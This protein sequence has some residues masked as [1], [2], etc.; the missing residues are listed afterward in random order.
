L[1]INDSLITNEPKIVGYESERYTENLFEIGRQVFSFKVQIALGNI[2]MELFDELHVSFVS[3]K[4][5]WIKASFWNQRPT[6]YWPR[7]KNK[8]Q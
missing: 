4:P 1:Y 2:S 8:K 6:D 5:D 7:L 3:R